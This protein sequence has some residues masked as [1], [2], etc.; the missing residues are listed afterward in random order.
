MAA[1]TRPGP[2]FVG[3]METVETLRRRFDDAR[4][5]IGGVTLLVGD[6]GVG[7]SV[8][9]AELAEE[10]RSRG[11]LVVASRALALDEPP[12][13]SLIRDA[14]EGVGEDPAV[15][16]GGARP[17][18]AEPVLIGFAPRLGEEA[19]SA[20]VSIETRLLEALSGPTD[21]GELSREHVLEGIAEQFRQFTGRGTTVLV[22]E[23]LHRADEAS[24]SA[25]EFLAEQ[26]KNE[27]LWVLGTS[28][29]P[30]SLSDSGRQRL[31]KFETVAHA[32]RVPLRALNSEEVGVY[33][34]AQEPT[35][36]FST[37]EVARRYSET[38][39]NPLL[40]AQ[41]DHRLASPESAGVA[42]ADLPSVDAEARRTLEVASV[43]GPEFPFALLL[44]A[45]GEEDE[46]RLTETIDRMVAHGLL[47]ERPGEVLQFPEDRLREE[48]YNHL[49][50]RQRRLLHRRA[51]E[52]LEAIGDVDV[53]MIYALARHFFLGRDGP[54]SVK[55]NRLAADVADRN[56][57]LDSAWEYYARA[58]ESE[59]SLLPDDRNGEAELVVELARVTEELGLLQDAETILR[60]FL[61]GTADDPALAP[62]RRATLEVFL[63]RVLA[64]EG[65]HP[66]AVELARKV[67]ATPGVDSQPLLRIAAHHLIG[68]AYYY[69]GRYPEALASHTEE[70]R[71]ARE[72][73]SVPVL[74]R[75]QFWHAATLAMMGRM[76]EAVAEAREV[77][78]GR[79]RLGSVR[80]SAQAHLYLGDI[81]AD[82][83]CPP[84][85]RQ[86]AIAEYAEAIRFAQKARDPRRT[87]YAL[88]KT[89]E[90]L[91]EAGRREEALDTVEKACDL[92]NR[93]GDH[94]GLAVSLK[95]RA[96]VAMDQGRYDRAQADLD[97]ARRLLRG[98]QHRLEDADV[99]LCLGQLA[100]LK[101]DRAKAAEYVAHLEKEE[102]PKIRPD[103][104]RDFE[105]LKSSLA[106]AEGDGVRA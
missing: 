76:D 6:T 68:P 32:V 106:G 83:R 49:P 2:T 40:L 14:I 41:L 20:P 58:L 81:L 103:L 73:G 9:I 93:V 38:G 92:L 10:M 7:K 33:L 78:A 57:A 37:E 87:G 91:R 95:A 15:G 39:G 31:E 12:P 67:L 84:A 3:R 97:E 53:A 8:L 101:N 42:D 75:A 30:G 89:T 86:E 35:R 48:V 19:F 4:A 85:Q 61:D 28:R 63:G 100:L 27:P 34:R 54:R 66:A 24:L 71:L 17:L 36:E 64:D 65:D 5:G 11:V 90:L 25:V 55:Y 29:L 79:D 69:A 43:L 60:E 96:Q 51:G 16:A 23:D 88:Y 52:A 102:L 62:E 13:F 104:A 82:A 1:E 50:D 74:L 99:V 18:V 22:L 72:V 26:L 59:R 94:V 46:E 77:T 80:E 98:L 47:F 70:I 56:L 44:Q 45:S 105:R 21:R